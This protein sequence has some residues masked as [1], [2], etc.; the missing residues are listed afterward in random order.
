MKQITK[1]DVKKALGER[2]WVGLAVANVV[3][4]VVAVIIIIISIEPKETQVITHYSSYGIAT[5]YRS[6]WYHLY[7][8]VVL[9]LIMAGTS[10][11]L[12]LKLL[13]LNRRDLALSV[14]W[15]GLGMLG[16]LTI[17][18]LSIISIAALG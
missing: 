5:F 10:I 2:W 6:Y 11:M 1:I 14:L 16:V 17:F 8:Y 3:A 13:H 9:A 4:M 12:S 18:A 15:A 7:G